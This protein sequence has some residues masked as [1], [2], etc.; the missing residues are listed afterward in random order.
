MQGLADGY[1]VIPYTLGHFIASN[2]LGSVD[3]NHGAFKAS[4]DECQK[5]INRFLN[6]KGSVPVD[7]IHRNL[8]KI[9]WENVGM[10]RS[11]ESLEKALNEIPKL[12]DRFWNDVRVSGSLTH[13]NMEVEKAGRVADFLELGELMAKDALVREESCGG[14]FREEYQTPENE[15][16]RNDND[17]CHVSAWER[18]DNYWALYKEPLNFK[19]V[20][21]AT[22]SYK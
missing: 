19:Y 12:R 5:K 21:L 1:F 13:M 22:R 14:H 9:M 6:V 17:F 3:E 2:E 18:S 20:K 8:G 15:A 10:S 11:K 7:E 4:A 16:L